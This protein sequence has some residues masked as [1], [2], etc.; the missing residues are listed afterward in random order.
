MDFTY[1]T[2][3][4]FFEWHVIDRSLRHVNEEGFYLEEAH[5]TP[6]DVQRFLEAEG[7]DDTDQPPAQRWRV[8][9]IL[10]FNVDKCE[11]I[12]KVLGQNPSRLLSDPTPLRIEILI[13]RSTGYSWRY[14]DSPEALFYSEDSN[15]PLM[16]YWQK[17]TAPND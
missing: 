6:D 14:C 11:P 1:E 4:R 7:K 3:V 5:V 17:E 8:G 15:D 13:T 12:C 2:L 9:D 10:V 16:E